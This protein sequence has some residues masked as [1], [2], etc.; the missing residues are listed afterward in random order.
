MKA[1]A[2]FAALLTLGIATFL[3][4]DIVTGISSLNKRA[5]LAAPGVYRNFDVLP[6]DQVMGKI[7]SIVMLLVLVY[8]L[9]WVIEGLCKLQVWSWWAAIGTYL[10]FIA[11]LNARLKSNS[12]TEITDRC[13]FNYCTLSALIVILSAPVFSSVPKKPGPS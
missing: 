9:R 2:R 1:L 7:A 11:D 5:G 4:R 13:I 10:L 12:P 3:A 8:F 6:Y